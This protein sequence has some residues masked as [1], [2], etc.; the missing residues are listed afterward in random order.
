MRILVL[1]NFDVGLYNFRKELLKK[2]IDDGNEVY[3]SLPYGNR[4]EQLKEMGCKFVETELSRRGMNP[5]KDIKLFFKYIKIIGKIKPHKIITYTIK[6]N[7]YGGWAARIKN[8]P[9]YANITGLGTVFQGNGFV[10][11]LVV[12]M[13]KFAFK[14]A[15]KVFFENC[16][17]RDVILSKGIIKEQQACL[18]NGAGVNLDEYPLCE[19]PTD[20]KIRFL[21]IGRVMKEKGIDEL[22]H[23]AKRMHSEGKNAEFDIVGP[24]EDDYEAIIRELNDKGIIN[25]HGFQSDVKPFIK[26]AH[27]FVLPSYHEGMANTLLECGAMG[28]PLITSNIHGCLEAVVDG[29]TGYLCN[30][31]NSEDL[32]QKINSFIDIPYEQ[33]KQM[34]KRSHMHISSVFDKTKV[35]NDTLSEILGC[36]SKN[37]LFLTLLDFNSIYEKNIYT[38]LLRVFVNNGHNVSVVS[39]VERR[40]GGNTHI[41][42]QDNCKILKLKIGNM[43]KTNLI[44]K[45]ITTLLVENSF[46]R[47]IKKYFCDERFDLVLYSTPPITLV[48]VVDYVKKR[49]GA[50]SYL[51]LK[52]IFP[53]NA[54]DLGMFCKR[55]IIYSYF[56]AKEKRLYK[57]SDRIGCMSPANVEFLI[58]NNPEILKDKVEVCPNCIE[59][60]DINVTSYQKTEIRKKYGIPC[61][62]TV[63]VYG[64]NLGKPQGIEFLIECLKSQ[65]HRQDAFFFIVGSGTEYARLYNYYKQSG[66]NNL[67]VMPSLPKEDFDKMLVACDVGMIF[68]D[69]RFTIPNFPSRLL[70]YMQA[71][72]PVLAVTDTTTDIG[73]I[74]AD[75]GFG[76]W[77]ESGKIGDF[78]ACIDIV[79]NDDL[80]GKGKASKDYLLKNYTVDTGYK[81]IMENM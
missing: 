80:P 53:Q 73:R 40:N 21:F 10:T 29:Q 12:Q 68:L 58:N 31:R 26:N 54:V 11:N 9:L 24:F 7:I 39:P 55:G 77:T 76:W 41:I 43:Q 3:I 63:F 66:Q 35:V 16:E 46:K 79:L 52:D 78:E 14:K 57:I 56:R 19:Y 75:S 62:K 65:Q 20:A 38:D 60:E 34:G 59:V 47:A 49:D 50:S 48:S 37:V 69:K 51:L 72:L 2:L 22:L 30:V 1:T 8:K 42:E 28:R 71:S 27:C 32:Y 33:K 67:K 61:D 4:V 5:A 18:L 74:A 70:S 6:P 15:K 13:Y 64:G 25:Y 81:I 23:V 44:E 45:G 17:N 36:R